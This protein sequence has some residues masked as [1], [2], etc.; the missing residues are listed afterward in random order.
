[1]K[2][3]DIPNKNKPDKNQINVAI[4]VRVST[5]IQM[6]DGMGLEGQ[7]DTCKT[8]CR[9]KGYNIYKIYADEAI[10]G[11]TIAD[12]RKSYKNMLDDGKLGNFN[13]IV[14]YKLDRLGR[15]MSVIVNAVETL[16]QMNIKPIFVEDNINS[17]TDEGMLFLNIYASLSDHEIKVIK[18]RLTKGLENRRKRD[19]CI[20]GRLPYGYCRIDKKISAN[21][22]LINNVIY[23]FELFDR[24]ISMNR[25][26][27]QM[28]LLKIKT[29][30]GKDIWSASTVKCII[31]NRL[32][33]QGLE[34]VNNNENEVY[35]PK[36]IDNN[37]LQN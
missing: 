36:I 10:S 9:I 18:S 12:D 34:L 5:M 32:K 7:I 27:K 4:Y 24:G 21:P 3:L 8:Y 29:S 13:I 19:G 35:W 33:Y 14:F 17:I 2:P 31:N 25:I 6:T 20:G 16:Q 30:M 1:M 22:K 23:V 37:L 26:A 15:K 11:T 28:T